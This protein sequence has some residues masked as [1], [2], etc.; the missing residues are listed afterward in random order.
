MLLRAA[1]RPSI[2][3]PIR[4]SLPTGSSPRSAG[5]K[6]AARRSCPIST[7]RRIVATLGRACAVRPLTRRTNATPMTHTTQ[8]H[9]QNLPIMA[10]LA[11]TRTS[12]SRHSSFNTFSAHPSTRSQFHRGFVSVPTGAASQR[13]RVSATTFPH[14]STRRRRSLRPIGPASYVHTHTH[15]HTQTYSQTSHT[16]IHTNIHKHTQCTD[17]EHTPACAFVDA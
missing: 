7:A 11:H 9:S 12:L 17:T 13:R 10:D 14:L 5:R 4:A 3:A 15:K 1:R 6:L 2:P 8:Q 16:D